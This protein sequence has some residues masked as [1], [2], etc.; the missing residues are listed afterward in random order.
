M[1]GTILIIDAD[2]TRRMMLELQL[3][4]AWYRVVQATR[5]S[6]ALALAPRLRPDLIVVAMMLPDGDAPALR[7][8]F[9]GDPA[10]ARVPM[11]AL[12]APNDRAAR[13]HALA[14]GID[15]ALSVPVDD[16]LLQ[17]RIRSLLRAGFSGEGLGLSGSAPDLAGL[18]ERRA[19]FAPR[20]TG[21]KVAV[22][23]DRVKTAQDWRRAL[24]PHLPHA[25]SCHRID[26]PQPA[27]VPR[28]DAVVIE[29]DTATDAHAA[30]HLLAG[31]RAGG[32]TRDTAV[33]AVPPAGADHLAA[34]ALDRGAHDVAPRGFDAAELALRLKAQLRRKAEADRLRTTVQDGLRAALRDP[35][36]GLY[37]RRHALPH[38]NT[39]LLHAGQADETV[40][41]LLVDLDDFKRINDRHGHPVGDAVLTEAARRLRRALRGPDMIARHGGD[42]FLI[43]MPRTGQQEAGHAAARMCQA[44]GEV[45]IDAAAPAPPLRVTASIGLAFGP[46]HGDSTDPAAA[47]IGQADRALYAAKTQGRNRVSIAP[48]HA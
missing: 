32:A 3:G 8:R 35:L 17:A 1:H 19:R 37:N 45:P 7:A 39:A 25:L 43:V 22:L 21:T 42:E 33:I 2:A 44:L 14:A 46:T 18:A 20:P 12:T 48:E 36:T 4:A 13:L 34:E 40:A 10:L 27:L 9:D 16:R 15:D 28:P 26:V 29:L 11:I 41:V 30:L 6:D 5:L 23:T 24:S 47:V 31:L 38:L